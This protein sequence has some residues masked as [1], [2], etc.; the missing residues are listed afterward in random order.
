MRW[1]LLL[2]LVTASLYS[3]CSPPMATVMGNV[4]IDG[5]PLD[6]GVICYSPAEGEG[7][8]VTVNIVDGKYEL[9]ILPGKKFVQVS[10]PKVVGTRKDSDAPDATLV[11]ITEERLPERY[12]SGRELTFEVQPGFNTKDWS[13][14]SKGSQR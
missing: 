14:E 2:I 7:E 13:V 12:Y 3:G 4:T 9:Q 11:E 1:H 8:S 5:Q 6:K 10:A